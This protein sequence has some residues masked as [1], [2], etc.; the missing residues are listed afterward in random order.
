MSTSTVQQRQLRAMD[1]TTAPALT[2]MHLPIM[3]PRCLHCHVLSCPLGTVTVTIT[4][5]VTASWS[6]TYSD[7]W[8]CSPK[9]R[10]GNY[11]LHCRCTNAPTAKYLYVQ[12][13][14]IHNLFKVQQAAMPTDKA[15]SCHFK[16][17]LNSTTYSTH[18][19]LNYSILHQ[20]I[21]QSQNTECV[22]S[23]NLPS[24]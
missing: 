5:T 13:R 1:V 8:S 22:L 20:L 7:R 9:P 4:A 14:N 2:E 23:C 21:P 12:Y 11:I 24:L 17:F 3:T 16:T 15:L 6:P 18:E 19:S 10:P